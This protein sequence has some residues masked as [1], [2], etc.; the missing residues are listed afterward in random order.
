MGVAITYLLIIAHGSRRQAS[1][2][3]VMALATQL[4]E[5]ELNGVQQV[6]A[7][8]LELAE[9]GIAQSI[10]D[11]VLHGAT[12]IKVFPYFLAA[13]RHV[14]ADIPDLVARAA[15]NHPNID[16]GLLPHLGKSSGLI[17]L[18]SQQAML[19]TTVLPQMN[20]QLDD[21]VVIAKASPVSLELEPGTY[22]WCSCGRSQNQPFCDGS[23]ASTKMK[24]LA[25]EI[26]RA[27]RVSIC[28]CKHSKTPPYC[29]GSHRKL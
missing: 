17:S 23:H 21:E 10:D 25:F 22:Q 15:A 24:P 4:N 3:E 1:N 12:Q 28:Q 11:C 9:P 8:F 26:T 20:K 13:G 6:R 14:T 19:P 5:L 7:G 29:D 27:E 2:D 18:V 16:I